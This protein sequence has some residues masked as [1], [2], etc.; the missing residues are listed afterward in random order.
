MSAVVPVPAMSASTYASAGRKKPSILVLVGAYLPGY[1]A[2]GPIRPISSL[3]EQLGSDFEFRLV[4][5]DRDHGDRLAYV[6]D[7]EGLG[8]VVLEAM[9]CGIPAVCTRSGGPDG[10][11]TDGED[12]LLVPLDDPHALSG[13]I[14]RLLADDS[15]NSRMGEAARRTIEERYSR[16]VAGTRFRDVWKSL[17][18]ARSAAARG[19]AS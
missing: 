4:C 9:A 19:A 15:L 14:G 18:S 8:V 6:G 17:L 3:I 5:P 7:E 10:I 13:A 16:A 12:G 1:K 11:I 2:G